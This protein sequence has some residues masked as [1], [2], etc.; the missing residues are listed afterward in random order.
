[1][2]CAPELVSKPAKFS[3]SHT[4]FS[5]CKV[6]MPGVHLSDKDMNLNNQLENDLNRGRQEPELRFQLGFQLGLEFIFEFGFGLGL[7][8]G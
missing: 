3:F 4:L 8:L 5:N 1:M 6:F 7:G 2:V